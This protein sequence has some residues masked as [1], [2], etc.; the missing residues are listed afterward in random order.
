MNDRFLVVYNTCEINH[1]NVWWYIDCIQ[2]LLK[3]EYDNFQVAV[4]GCKIS[5]AT[6][7]ALMAKFGNKIC[8][9]YIEDIVPVNVTFNHTVDV[10]SKSKGP[11]DGY[12]YIDSGMNTQDK[13]TALSE[14][15]AR[16][17]TRQ[18]G[19]VTL[20]PSTDTGY[21]MWFG[22]PEVGYAFTGQDFIV[23]VGKAIPLHFQYFDHKLLEYYGR[24]IPDIFKTFCTESTFS[25]LNAALG[26]K[27]VIV[28]DLVIPHNKASDGPCG[29][30]KGNYYDE[31]GGRE[32]WNCLLGNL[33]IKK[34]IMTED[35][36][37]LG[38]GYEEAQGVF[39]HDSACY[40]AN[41]FALNPE[42]KSFIK[43]NLF[44]PREVV[45]YDKLTY[46]LIV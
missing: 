11:F 26:L 28:K 6:K 15:N 8:Y 43:K 9:N 30:V 35:G 32:P 14:I 40:D 37:R 27:W 44:V 46:K 4:S 18:F 3:Q 5:A 21:Q 45:D 10:I 23:P 38:M 2:N 24:V 20:Q 41:G 7:A 39:M 19:M 13:V 12:I 1:V 33:D 34:L 31:D 16:S 22:L 42:L 17:S 36:K 29:L 25:F